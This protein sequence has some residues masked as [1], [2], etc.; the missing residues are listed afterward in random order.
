MYEIFPRLG[1]RRT[2]DAGTM[3][4]GERQMLAMARALMPDPQVAAA[5]RAL[6]R[7]RAR[8]RRGDLPEDRGHQQR[9]GHDRDGRAER[10]PRARD[11]GPRLR[12]RPRQQPLRGQGLGP[13]GRPEGRRA[14]PRRHGPH[15]RRNNGLILER[16]RPGPEGPGRIARFAGVSPLGGLL[17]GC[18]RH[19]AGDLD[20]AARV[21]RRCHRHLRW[22]LRSHPGRAHRT[23]R[24]SRCHHR[25]AA[26]RS[27]RG[28][29]ARCTPYHPAR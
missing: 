4:G 2:Q 15:R 22:R 25:S 21:L 13:P 26:P 23:R 14:L 27:S 1:E 5:R 19:L 10:P 16:K 17:R 3:S 29:A 8:L 11:V 28:A 7:P 12:P 6:G 18:H 24:C 20:G 9:R